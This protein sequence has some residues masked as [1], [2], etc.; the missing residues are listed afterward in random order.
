MIDPRRKKIAEILAEALEIKD[1]GNRRVFLDRMCQGDPDLRKEIEQMLRKESA[2]EDFLEPLPER[3]GP[4][5]IIRKLGKGGMGV[6]YLAEREEPMRQ[7]V[8]L[9]VINSGMNTKEVLDRFDNERNLLAVLNCNGIAMIHDAGKT[10]DGEPYFAME[11]VPGLPLTDYCDQHRLNLK[12]RLELFLQLCR[13]IEHAHNKGII[14]R[15]LKPSNIIVETQ[16]D[17]PVAKIIDFGI[18]KATNQISY[19]LGRMIGTPAYM[20]PEQASGTPDGVDKRT[21]IYSLGVILYEL[22]V[23]ETP[24]SLDVE[25]IDAKEIRR[26]I[27]D[28]D[29][30]T[31][32]TKWMQLNRETTTR[33]SKLRHVDESSA[34]PKKIR[35]D[36]DWVTMMAIRKEPERRYDSANN[37]A[38]DIERFLRGEP[39]E[40]RP[41]SIIYRIKKYISRNRVMVMASSS[42]I[43]ALAS[44]LVVS[45]WFATIAWENAK[46]AREKEY[47]ASK[48]ASIA[49]EN[50]QKAIENAK[51]AAENE[52]LALLALVLDDRRREAAHLWPPG[53]S[54]EKMD[55]W[56]KRNDLSTLQLKP[57]VFRMKKESLQEMTFSSRREALK[58]EWYLECRR[59]LDNFYALNGIFEKVR[60]RKMR[61]EE[62]GPIVVSRWDKTIAEIRKKYPGVTIEVQNDLVPLWADP[63]SELWEFAHWPTWDEA[64]AIWN[65]DPDSKKPKPPLTEKTGLIFVLIPGG[66]LNSKPIDPFF[67]SKYEMT[68]AVWSRITDENP[69]QYLPGRE[70][71]GRVHTPLHPVERVSWEDCTEVLGYLG[72]V[73]PTEKLWEYAARGPE[74][75]NK[76]AWWTG[77]KKETL[78]GK[79]NIADISFRNVGGKYCE[80]WD[81][82]WVHHAPV[83]TFEANGFGL[84]DVAGNVFEWC[85]EWYEEPKYRVAR[86]GGCMSPADLAKSKYRDKNPPGLRA[87]DLGVRPARP[88]NLKR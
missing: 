62:M 17:R 84:H 1:P 59:R 50:E 82:Q 16:A 22:L 6:V 53:T 61:A 66:S 81:D 75:D 37:F 30:V 42:V 56:L 27:C 15:D 49:A 64:E 40:A 31:P 19:E 88:L 25:K 2:A 86:G 39:V 5:R 54:I 26:R 78:I 70:C 33:L 14:H 77:D 41:P 48:N 20:S 69:S 12:A 65:W 85:E 3:I 21:D 67:V 71:G 34:Y 76:F 83:G 74:P 4:Y 36:L 11:Y 60:R 87:P 44:G 58:H 38:K 29:P 13:A 10:E 9:K 28:E 18:A 72:M 57:A 51:L 63:Q 24:L 7:H 23:G 52:D 73:L 43:L 8:A 79:A 47:E 68:Q 55:E 35:D 32:S 45:I 46:V 80:D